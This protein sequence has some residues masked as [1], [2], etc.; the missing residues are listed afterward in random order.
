MNVKV[1]EKIQ[2][3]LEYVRLIISSANIGFWQWKLRIFELYVLPFL[4][5]YPGKMFHRGL[6]LIL[7][8]GKSVLERMNCLHEIVGPLGIYE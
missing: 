3:N 2:I 6:C 7:V 5:Y 4:T 8:I 1:H